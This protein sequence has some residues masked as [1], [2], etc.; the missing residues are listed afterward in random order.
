MR[1]FQGSLHAPIYL[2]RKVL[3]IIVMS[4]VPG[5]IDLLVPGVDGSPVL[6]GDQRAIHPS[7][8]DLH[9]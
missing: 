8:N 4:E 2:V 6:L 3:K 1:G 5:K 9:D 7:L